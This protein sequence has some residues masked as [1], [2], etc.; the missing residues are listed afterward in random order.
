[1]VIVVKWPTNLLGIG[2]S[3]QQPA[4]R[5]SWSEWCNIKDTGFGI[6][7]STQ[8]DS[9]TLDAYVWVKPGGE[10]DGTSDTTATRYDEH[11]SSTSSMQPA[12][13]AGEWFQAYFERLIELADPPF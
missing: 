1:M 6:R 2:R 4:G 7:P 13:E 8:T 3:G 9:E 12:P 10:A 11:C 5:D